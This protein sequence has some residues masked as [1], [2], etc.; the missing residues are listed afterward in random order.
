M[1]NYDPDTDSEGFRLAEVTKRGYVRGIGSLDTFKIKEV[2]YIEVD[3]EAVFEGCIVLGTIEEMAELTSKVD[4]FGGIDKA[5]QIESF[6]IT[7]SGQRYLWPLGI[8]P[9]TID[10]NLPNQARVSDA[11]AHWEE[12]SNFRFVKLN[13]NNA[14][15]YPD[16]ITFRP[17]RGCSS[18]VGRA[19]G[20]QFINLGP[21]CTKGNTIHEIGHAIGLWHEQ[22][23]EDRDEF[24]E[25]KLENVIDRARHNFNQHI[26]DGDDR[27]DYD[28]GSIMHY[29]SHAFS[30]NGQ[31]TIVPKDGSPIGQRDRLSDRDVAA[32]HEAYQ[33]EFAKRS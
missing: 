15:Q 6:G 17:A 11:I 21:N 5:S 1:S 9:Y 19:G 30:K 8:I 31:P 24:V 2:E 22:S 18:R 12:R 10:Q 25:V 29:P 14:D 7:R 33:N 27:G 28:Y 13:S 20:Q 26:M 16:F 23:R 4:Q 32:V 3:G